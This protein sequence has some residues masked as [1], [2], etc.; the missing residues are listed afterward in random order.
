MVGRQSM[1]KET[2]GEGLGERVEQEALGKS[3]EHVSS[4]EVKRKKRVQQS[5]KAL[6]G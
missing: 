3:T 4:R 5:N 1:G 6:C 2:G